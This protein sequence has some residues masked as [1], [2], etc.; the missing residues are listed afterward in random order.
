MTRAAKVGGARAGA[1]RK[2]RA[3]VAASVV[4]RYAVTPDESHEIHRALKL[5]QRNHTE[6]ARELM[7]GW[8]RRQRRRG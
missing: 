5:E 7:L 3:G 8:A 6:V 1:G 4:E 2:P